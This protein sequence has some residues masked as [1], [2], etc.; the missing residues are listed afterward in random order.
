MIKSV[1][2]DLV[3]GTTNFTVREEGVP[4]ELLASPDGRT[5]TLSSTSVERQ[6]LP[7]IIGT[8]ALDKTSMLDE[9]ASQSATASVSMNPAMRR[10]VDDLVGEEEDT[11]SDGDPNIVNCPQAIIPPNPTL[12]DWAFQAPGND[13]SY[14]TIGTLTA[15]DLLQEVATPSSAH[16]LY[17]TPRPILP[18]IYN[19]PF[20]PLPSDATPSPKPCP[21]TAKRAQGHSKQNSGNF[22]PL[23]PLPHGWSVHSSNTSSMPDPSSMVLPRTPAN[24]HSTTFPS[25]LGNGTFGAGNTFMSSAVLNGSPR[26]F[27]SAFNGADSQMDY[28]NG[29]ETVANSGPDEGTPKRGSNAVEPVS[30]MCK[31]CRADSFRSNNELHKH[32][33]A[34]K[35]RGRGGNVHATPPNGQGG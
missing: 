20:A 27:D 24:G 29:K 11:V 31:R 3:D 2:M 16:Q 8:V 5:A 10:M 35:G 25:H 7:E 19:T 22:S 4:S 33:K 14:G 17:S 34:C 28:Q 26:A 21:S 32:L 12:N 18:S 13:T 30:R 6:D 15:H 23:Q 1:P 9:G